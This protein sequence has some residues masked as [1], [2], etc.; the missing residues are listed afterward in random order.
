MQATRATGGA[1]AKWDDLFTLQDGVLARKVTA[2]GQ[3]GNDYGVLYFNN[4]DRKNFELVYSAKGNSDNGWF[5]AFFAMTNKT[6][7]GNQTGGSA[8]MQNASAAHNATIWGGN[9]R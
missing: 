5:G 7:A 6:Q 2:A 9:S 3:V 4:R 8:F 1:A